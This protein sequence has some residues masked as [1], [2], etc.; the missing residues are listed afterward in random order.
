MSYCRK[1][2]SQIDEEAVICPK[3]GVPTNL[4]KRDTEVVVESSADFNN[5]REESKYMKKHDKGLF[6]GLRVIGGIG[7][8]AGGFFGAL[9]V[10]SNGKPYILLVAWIVLVL[11]SIPGIIFGCVL[12][13]RGYKHNGTAM[14]VSYSLLPIVLVLLYVMLTAMKVI[15]Y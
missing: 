6:T 8:G 1:C 11:G 7:G 10:M 4:Y 5:F 14:L 9:A 12:L 13:S 2:G 3:C 15:R